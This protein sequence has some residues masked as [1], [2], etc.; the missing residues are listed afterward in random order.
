MSVPQSIAV[1][2]APALAPQSQNPVREQTDK[3][4]TIM[5]GCEPVF[6]SVTVPQMAHV[7]GRC[8]G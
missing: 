8:V 7:A 1:K 2:K 4:R 6:S 3:R 5:D